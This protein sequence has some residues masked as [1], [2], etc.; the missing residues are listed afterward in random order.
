MVVPLETDPALKTPKQYK[1]RITQKQ[2]IR[3]PD[4][5]HTRNVQKT[6][7]ISFKKQQTD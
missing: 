3:L 4:E 7:S 1:A 5:W 6:L 2:I